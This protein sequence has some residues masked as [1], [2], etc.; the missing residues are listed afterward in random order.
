MNDIVMSWNMLEQ[1]TVS[2]GILKPQ[3]HG[4]KKKHDVWDFRLPSGSAM[5]K[6]VKPTTFASDQTTWTNHVPLWQ[7]W[8]A[9]EKDHLQTVD[10]SIIN[11]VFP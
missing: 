2:G 8:I 3:D 6:T 5:V 4:K 7:F 1:S 10:L 11:G 9:I